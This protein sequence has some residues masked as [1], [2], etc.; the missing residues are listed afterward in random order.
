MTCKHCGYINDGNSGFCAMCGA[1]LIA[2]TAPQPQQ[3]AYSYEDYSINE[4]DFNQDFNQQNAYAQQPQQPYAQQPYAQQPNYA[5]AEPKNPGQGPGIAS[6]VIGIVSWLCCNPAFLLSIVAIICG[7]IGRKKSKEAGMKNGTAT[8]GLALGI[9]PLVISAVI[10]I[11]G[12][13]LAGVMIATMGFDEFM[14]TMEEIIEEFMYMMEEALD[15]LTYIIEDIFREL[16][17]YYY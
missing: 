4:Q 14:W 8:A 13:V 12:L 10:V 3:P 17:I 5:P 9:I 15:Y 16:G 6:L 11:V 2:E 7:A 1:Q